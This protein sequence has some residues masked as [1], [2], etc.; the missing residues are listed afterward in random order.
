M[1][2]GGNGGFGRRFRIRGIDR[3]FRIRGID[4]RFRIRG[5]D[6]RRGQSFGRQS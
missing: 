4:R 6:R 5:I 3:R 2:H 1:G